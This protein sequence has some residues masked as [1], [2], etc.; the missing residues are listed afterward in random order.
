[1]A[2][3]ERDHGQHDGRQKTEHR[4]RLQNV[5]DRDHPRLDARVIGSDVSVGDGEG[6]AE[7]V[8][9]GHAHDGVEGVERQSA[10]G[11]RNGH[12]R[13]RFLEPINAGA[14]DGEENR[15]GARRDAQIDDEGRAASGDESAC[16]RTLKV[17]FLSS[18]GAISSSSASGSTKRRRAASKSNSSA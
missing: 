7:H 6:Q 12:H 15:Q 9:D 2:G 13:N 3:N 16:E 8:G 18:L 11:A 4:N 10:N 5:E 1:M 14:D 17:H